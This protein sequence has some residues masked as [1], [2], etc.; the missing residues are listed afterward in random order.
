MGTV[1]AQRATSGLDRRDAAVVLPAARGR[2]R[3]G[4]GERLGPTGGRIVAEV[5]VGL[6]K[7]DPSSFLRQAP[8]WKPELPSAEPGHFTMADLLRFAGV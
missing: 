1:G 4:T 8:A 3:C 2:G 5:L 6:L 7:G